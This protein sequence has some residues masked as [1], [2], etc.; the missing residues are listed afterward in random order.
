MA[1]LM[2]GEVQDLPVTAALK[3]QEFSKTVVRGA[4]GTIP[5]L[6]DITSHV[7]APSEACGKNLE[8]TSLIRRPV[9]QYDARVKPNIA[10][11]TTEQ[12][13]GTA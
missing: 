6:N 2:Q 1:Y 3:G 13:A 10:I 8:G 4:H 9:P 7:L 5:V 12:A 11:T